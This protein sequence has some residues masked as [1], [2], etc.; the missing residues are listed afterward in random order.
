MSDSNGRSR[1]VFRFKQFS[2]SNGLSAQKVGTDGVIVGALASC[3]SPGEIWD[4]GA[5]TGLIAMMLAQRF[6]HSHLSA[7]EIDMVSAAEC[8]ANVASSPWC[9][10][11]DVVEG[12]INDLISSLPSPDL[13]VSN[14]PFFS[15]NGASSPDR[16]RAVARQDGSLSPFSLIKMANEILS[17]S[18]RLV[19]I[20]PFDRNDAIMLSAELNRMEV[21]G[22][23]DIA[24]RS[25]RMPIRRVWT[26]MRKQE[27]VGIGQ[28]EV[29][30]IDIRLAAPDS[31]FSKE[32]VALT[33][34]FYLDF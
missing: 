10:R 27:A 25:D 8:R 2:V 33:R 19:F 4:V 29:E 1:K 15:G 16:R 28:G 22:R 14:P 7:I 30:R 11:I 20:A 3:G 18:G 13:I 24:S 17:K 5:G 26:M 6:P 31:P 12:D 34:D 23:T 32:Y 9:D 21:V